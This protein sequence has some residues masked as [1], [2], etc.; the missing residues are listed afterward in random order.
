MAFD[1]P[2]L[3]HFHHQ[4]FWSQGANLDPPARCTYSLGLAGKSKLMTL[5]RRGMSRPRAATS[6]TT[7]TRAL[8]ALNLA[9]AICLATC[10][11]KG[12]VLACSESQPAAAGFPEKHGLGQCL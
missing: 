2:V 10:M 5:S 4:H 6:V 3:P 7:R 8:P 12:R 9:V 1:E 11:G